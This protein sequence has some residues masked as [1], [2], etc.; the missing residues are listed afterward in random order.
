KD[1]DGCLNVSKRMEV[2]IRRA[3]DEDRWPLVMGQRTYDRARAEEIVQ[4]C[5]RLVEQRKPFLQIYDDALARLDQASNA[6]KRELA[7]LKNL[8]EQVALD[9]ERVRLTKTVGDLAQ[10]QRTE[11]EIAHYSR[12]LT[13]AVEETATTLPKAGDV[14]AP[15]DAESLLK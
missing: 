11:N 1:V 14:P 2:A 6:I 13:S 8:R 9:L 4:G 10:L 7:E 5:T 12:I 3:D 15:V